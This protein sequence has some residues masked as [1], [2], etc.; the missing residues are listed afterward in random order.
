MSPLSRQTQES[1]LHTMAKH[2]R[3]AIGVTESG[4]LVIIVYS[5]RSRYSSGADYREM[6]D[7][8]RHL[9]PDI[10]TLMNADGG[11]SAVL[12]LVVNGSLME[13]SLPAASTDSCVGMVRPINTVLY[14]AAEQS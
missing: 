1:S 8:A 4:A 5:G 6:I 2:P 14:L 13:L 10:R 11:G 3:T 7:I 12:G 9:Y